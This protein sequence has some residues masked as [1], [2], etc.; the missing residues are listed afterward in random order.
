MG[1]KDFLVLFKEW[2]SLQ[3]VCSMAYI[4]WKWK[5][6]WLK[7]FFVFVDWT[8]HKRSLIWPLTLPNGK[9]LLFWLWVWGN[10][11]QL[12]NNSVL[13]P[14]ILSNVVKKAKKR[15]VFC[16]QNCSDQLWEKNVLVIEEKL[17]NSRLNAKNLQ[18]F[19]DH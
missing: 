2:L 9:T 7:P 4:W 18:K 19:W 10:R 1:L 15:M 6:L 3:L 17:C 16:Y 12:S 5:A 11:R 13:M 8:W 14:I